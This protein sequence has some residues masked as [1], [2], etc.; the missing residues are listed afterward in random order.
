MTKKVLESEEA[1][2]TIAR[3]LVVGK[4]QAEIAVTFG[5]H[6]STISRFATR[7]DVRKFIE[8]ENQRLMEAVP[9]AVG[10]VIRLVQ[11]MK[12]IPPKE[13]KRLELSYKA[14]NDVLKAAGLMCRSQDLI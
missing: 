7:E 3:A 2:Q 6:Q 13:T 12:D 5:V 14:Y 4:S 1:K 9:D 10:N 8:L 11:E